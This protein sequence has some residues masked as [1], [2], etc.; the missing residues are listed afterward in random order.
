[1]KYKLKLIMVMEDCS[2]LVVYMI[3]NLRYRRQMLKGEK[4][5]NCMACNWSDL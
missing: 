3:K 5:V 4:K 2:S 1:M